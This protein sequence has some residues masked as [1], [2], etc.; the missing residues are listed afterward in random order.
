VEEV[1]VQK[2]LLATLLLLVFPLSLWGQ[3]PTFDP[4][5]SIALVFSSSV[6]GEV[7]PCG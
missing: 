2:Y 6:S 5:R 7:E 3:T 4:D 1:R